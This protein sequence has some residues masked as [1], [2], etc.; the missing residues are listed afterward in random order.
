[1]YARVSVPPPPGPAPSLGLSDWPS[2]PMRGLG[3]PLADPPAS[4][5]VG[6]Q[7]RSPVLGPGLPGPLALCTPVIGPGPV[8]WWMSGRSLPFISGCGCQR[9]P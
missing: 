9:V 6:A 4:L 7:R 8:R 5:P 1:M 3:G 2:L